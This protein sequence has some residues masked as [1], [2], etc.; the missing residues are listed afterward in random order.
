[1]LCIS[2]AHYDIIVRGDIIMVIDRFEDGFAV[3]FIGSQKL[4]IARSLLPSDVREGDM[5][6]PAADGRYAVDKEK[7]ASKRTAMRTRMA[8]LFSKSISDDSD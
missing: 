3:C 7:T 1:M 8:S 5:L 6:V 2:D 4:L